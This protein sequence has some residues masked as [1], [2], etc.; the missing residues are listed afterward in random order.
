MS[1][2]TKGPWYPVFNSADR[3]DV[4]VGPGPYDQCVA[5]VIRNKYIDGSDEAN[6][7][8]IAAAPD[9]LEA[10]SR[11]LRDSGCDGDLCMHEWHEKARAAIARAKGEL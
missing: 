10:L 2:Y 5:S 4:S 9:L 11:A 6:A 1:N 7:R 8:L 3:W